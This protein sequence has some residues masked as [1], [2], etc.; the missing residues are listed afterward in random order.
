VR[1]K[2][3]KV[4]AKFEVNE[5]G[6]I[7]AEE[8]SVKFAYERERKKVFFVDNV[9]VVTS[10]TKRNNAK[11]LTWRRFGLQV[12]SDRMVRLASRTSTRSI[13]AMETD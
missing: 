8:F 9:S 12:S 2:I 7:D 4:E 3:N 1:K 11:T 6:L 10:L 13:S 5:N